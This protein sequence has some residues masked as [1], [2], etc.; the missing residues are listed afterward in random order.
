MLCPMRLNDYLADKRMT[1]EE[2]AMA[3]GVTSAALSRYVTGDRVPR[4]AIMRKII[5]LTAGR[6]TPNDFICPVDEQEL[7]RSKTA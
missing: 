1:A 7:R 4:P 5:D 6:V 3:L 2:F